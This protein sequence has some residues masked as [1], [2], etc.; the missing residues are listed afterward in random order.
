MAAAREFA[1]GPGED[2]LRLDRFLCKLLRQ[3]P[4]NAIF[5]HLREGRIRVD[6]QKAKGDLRLRPGMTVAV[7]LREEDLAAAGT[8]RGG[9]HGAFSG[10]APRIVHRDEDLLVV[11]KPA[12]LATQ[13][14]SGLGDDHLLAWLQHEGLGEPTAT[15]RPAPAH[16]IDR[17]TSGLVV[18]GLTPRG[19]R[20]AAEAFREDRVQKIYFAVV[21][22][23]PRQRRFTIDAPLLELQNARAQ[24]PRVVVDPAGRPAKTVCE[25][26]DARGER[27]LVRVELLTGRMHQIRAH[28][29]HAGHPIVG[30]ARY[31]SPTRLTV[32]QG[33]AA[34]GGRTFLLHAAELT[35]P[36]PVTG[37]RSKFSA[38]APA[39]FWIPEERG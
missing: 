38:P 25:V 13:P 32:R 36:H 20:A 4:R 11:D 28:L 29:A 30:D 19:L 34:S 27:A 14:G 6:G 16:R 33:G 39:G 21:H 3:V 8:L 1:V 10:E 31:G 18:I 24:R 37:A 26:L 15:F 9:R 2:G 7:G 12:G 35:M 5:R 17:G 22:G 23:V